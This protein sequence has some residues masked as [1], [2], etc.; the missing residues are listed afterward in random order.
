MFAGIWFVPEVVAADEV[1]AFC[2]L[3]QAGRPFRLFSCGKAIEGVV[4]L[5]DPQAKLA[6]ALGAG[7]G[8]FA[9]LRPDSYLAGVASGAAAAAA[10]LATVL[11]TRS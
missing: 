4:A 3:E 7:H 11:P 9:L 5:T 10:M 2:A 6:G 8:D 1:A